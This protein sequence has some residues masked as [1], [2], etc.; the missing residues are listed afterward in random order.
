MYALPE[1]NYLDLTIT[2]PNIGVREIMPVTSFL[3]CIE[4]ILPKVIG[5]SKLWNVKFLNYR[6]YTASV[7]EF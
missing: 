2:N 6:Y 1:I 7:S 3:P 4:S 5:V